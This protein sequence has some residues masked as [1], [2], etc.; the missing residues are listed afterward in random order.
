[1]WVREERAMA[2]LRMISWYMLR[3]SNA[4]LNMN[5]NRLTKT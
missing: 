4:D 5:P 2:Y 1:M 3:G